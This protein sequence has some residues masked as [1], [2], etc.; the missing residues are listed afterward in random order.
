MQVI[1]VPGQRDRRQPERSK[2]YDIW[3]AIL[4]STADCLVTFDERFANDVERI[5][6]LGGFRVVRTLAE[7]ISEAHRP[8]AAR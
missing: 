6:G 7:V 4:A 3:H 2:G 1:G 8:P 5:P